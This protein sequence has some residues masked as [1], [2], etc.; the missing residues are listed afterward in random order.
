[1]FYEGNEWEIVP[2]MVLFA[3][4]ILMDSDSGTAMCLGRSSIVTVNDPEPLS[5]ASLDLIVK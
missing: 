2:G 3:H 1:M 4:M 5:S